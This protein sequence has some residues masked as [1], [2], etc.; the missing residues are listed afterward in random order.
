MPLAERQQALREA[1]ALA[2]QTN[3]M[4]QTIFSELNDLTYGRGVNGRPVSIEDAKRIVA[5]NL[6][7]SGYADSVIAPLLAEY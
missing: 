6:R 3:S 7:A 4:R 2:G 5:D 1:E